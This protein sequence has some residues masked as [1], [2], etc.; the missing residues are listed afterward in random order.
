MLLRVD[1]DEERRNVHKLLPHTNVALADED[2]GV[3]DGLRQRL[4]VHLGLQREGGREG[5]GKGRISVEL[6]Q[7]RQDI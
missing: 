4:L 1:T 5:G 7:R 3:V 6:S 2:T